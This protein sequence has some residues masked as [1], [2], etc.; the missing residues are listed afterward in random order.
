VR[1]TRS[2]FNRNKADLRIV[3]GSVEGTSADVFLYEEIGFW[4]VNAQDFT[5]E[6]NALDVATIHLHINSPGGSVFDGMAMANALREHKAKV[7][8]HIDALAA[9]I[10]TI[11]ALAGDEVHMADN[12]FFMIHNAWT[13][14]M[15]N[16]EDLR[17]DA[18]LLDKMDTAIVNQYMKRTNEDEKQVR[19]WMAEEKW[20]DAQEALD[21]GFI[22]KIVGEEVEEALDAAAMFD[23]SVYSKVPREF[24]ARA[25]RDAPPT[26]R[27]AER[28]LRDVGFSRVA[29]KQVV[30]A[31]IGAVERR[32]DNSLTETLAAGRKLITLLKS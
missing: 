23:L 29:A 14:S 19:A 10:A 25:R 22:D 13:L 5:R 18:S 4:G 21:A 11:I 7:I 2:P 12:A 27:D 17:K 32:D 28:A 20:F 31:G 16:A 1:K 8:V 24:A 9:S 15:G 6:I 26:A 30:A 3:R